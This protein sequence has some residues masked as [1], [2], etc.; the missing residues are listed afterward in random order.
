[1][2]SGEEK[3]PE[4]PACGS[5]W[6]VWLNRPVNNGQRIYNQQKVRESG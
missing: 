2:K 6:M 4:C 5:D 1:M 3:K